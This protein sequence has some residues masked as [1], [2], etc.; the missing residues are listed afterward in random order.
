MIR[1]VSSDDDD[2]RFLSLIQ[3]IIGAVAV[4]EHTNCSSFRPTD[5]L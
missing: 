3:R 1:L 4:L 5:P 2:P